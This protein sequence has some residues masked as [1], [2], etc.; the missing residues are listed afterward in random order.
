MISAQQWPPA[1]PPVGQALL[2]TRCPREAGRHPQNQGRTPRQ[3]VQAPMTDPRRPTCP[4]RLPLP[5]AFL[6]LHKCKL[7]TPSH[8]RQL[9]R[10]GLALGKSANICGVMVNPTSRL[11][12]RGPQPS[13]REL[14]RDCV[15]P[16]WA[17]MPGAPP[18]PWGRARSCPHRMDGGAEARAGQ[19]S[20]Q[21]SRAPGKT[22]LRG[23]SLQTVVGG[24]PRECV[25]WAWSARTAS[26][27]RLLG[28]GAPAV[29]P[30]C[31]VSVPVCRKG[32]KGRPN[33]STLRPKQG[34]RRSSLLP[35]ATAN[36]HT[37]HHRDYYYVTGSGSNSR[38][39][40]RLSSPGRWPH[41]TPRHGELTAAS[42]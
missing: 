42:R 9:P 15:S 13:D 4:A 38:C 2:V 6:F 41:T 21:G 36:A 8:P 29:S 32:W 37:C 17:V 19:P 34:E 1:P 3:A 7:W 10:A 23:S 33:V 30:L 26:S 24:G 11:Q 16:T 12:S 31:W 14:C 35:T 18:R 20:S 5:S 27:Q 39:P 25:P 40:R 22:V 28:P